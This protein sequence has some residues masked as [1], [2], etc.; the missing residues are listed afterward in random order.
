[1]IV[2]VPECSLDVAILDNQLPD[3]ESRTAFP[4]NQ[5]SPRKSSHK[6][7]MPQK[8]GHAPK[9]RAMPQSDAGAHA[10]G[11]ARRDGDCTGV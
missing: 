7:S 9:K 4:E 6:Q 10:G 8:A 5:E 11:G 1:M 3:D 2:F